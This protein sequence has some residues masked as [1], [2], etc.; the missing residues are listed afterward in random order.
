MRNKYA[1][2]HVLLRDGVFY[3]VR[4]VPLDLAEQYSVKR[5]C[6]SLR[7][8]S[9]KSAIHASKSVSQRLEDYWLG[10]RL[11]KIDIPALELVKSDD[12]S[13]DNCLLSEAR[14]LYLRLKAGGKDKVFI[15]TATRNS[16]YVIK[17][18]GDRPLGSYSSSEAAQFRDWCLQQGMTIRT[19]KRVF[20][21]IRAIVNIAITEHGYDCSNAFSKTF[22]PEEENVSK[23]KPIPIEDI[24]NIQAKCMEMDDDMRWLI[25]LISDTGMRLAE[26]AGLL[27]SDVHL[28]A[29]IPFVRIQKHLWR[30]LK[31]ASSERLIPLCGQALWAAKRIVASDQT[32]KFAFPRY[33][34]HSTTKANSASAALNKWLKQYVPTGCTMHSFRHSMRDRLRAVQ[35]PADI[36]DQI[37]GWAADGVGQG[38]GS[39]YPIDVTYDW[40]RQAIAQNVR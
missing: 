18:L 35:C 39:G 26:G 21:S 14:E 4:R 19:V 3:Y 24:R 28:D 12:V 9:Y 31:T 30:N 10:L 13:D 29:D 6:F 36:A 8:K 16:D 27:K 17:L 2:N 25:A 1:A 34:R 33:N 38:Y 7:T 22:F 15:R 37:G 11:Q 23:R 5:L 32:S 20:A 40:V